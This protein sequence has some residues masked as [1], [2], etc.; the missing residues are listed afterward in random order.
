M[1][2]FSLTINKNLTEKLIIYKNIAKKFNFFKR[3]F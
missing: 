3:F 1:V 2:G